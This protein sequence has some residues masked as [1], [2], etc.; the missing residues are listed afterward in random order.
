LH[1][2]KEKH[3]TPVPWVVANSFD[4]DSLLW[5]QAE[6]LVDQV[7]EVVSEEA[8]WLALSMCSPEDV[9]LLGSKNFVVWVV[10]DCLF[11]WRSTSEHDEQDDT[12]CEQVNF[13]A[14]VILASDLWC[15]VA[16]GSEFSGKSSPLEEG[17]KPEVSQS[18]SELIVQ[19]N[20]LWL[21]VSVTDAFAM[22]IGKGVDQHVEV[23]SGYLS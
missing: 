5:L 16:L 7:F 12:C 20:V 10:R 2:I 4:I 19:K 3:V 15:H 6:H 8:S 22:D 9:I 18:Q 17:G 1:I 11:E 23:G 21:D 13:L 14:L